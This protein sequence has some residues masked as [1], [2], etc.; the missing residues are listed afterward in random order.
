M[1][2][3]SVYF[4]QTTSKTLQRYINRVASKTGN[5]FMVDNHVLP[6]MT[7]SAIEA[8]NIEVLIPAVES[9]RGKIKAGPVQF[10]TIGQIPIDN[11]INLCYSYKCLNG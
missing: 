5:R 9:L 2:L 11:A 8:P 6:H 7:I 3:I 10:V 4:D 1:Y